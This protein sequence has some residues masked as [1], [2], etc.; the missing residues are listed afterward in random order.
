VVGPESLDLAGRVAVVTGAARGIGAAV[1]GALARCGADLALVD[2]D[3]GALAETAR[4][5]E[6]HGRRVWPSAFDVRDREAAG[7]LARRLAD[8]TRGIDLLVNNAGGTFRADFAEVS[9][10]GERALLEVN[11]AQAASFIRALLPL[12]R[13]GGG[14][15][16]NVTSVEAH[17]AAPG[18][19]VYAAAKAALESL[20]RS[21]ALELA[22]RRIRVNCV[23]PDAIPTPGTGG[24]APPTPWPDAG[25]PEDVA[26]AVLYLASDLSRFVT[27]TTLHVDGG[28]LAAGG[29]RRD[30]SQP[31][32]WTL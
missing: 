26:G 13:E 31:G 27:G 22:D 2:R 11:F 7:V 21:L 16:V 28:S 3:A 4:A 30:P 10:G 20:S 25:S 15:I 9:E 6:D 23:A 24:A 14:S 8:E 19:A 32:G 29:W 18:Y 5:L 12:F 17:R 1:A